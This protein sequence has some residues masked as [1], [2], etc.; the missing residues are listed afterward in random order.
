MRPCATGG[1]ACAAA[2]GGPTSRGPSTKYAPNTAITKTA[3]KSSGAVQLDLSTRRETSFEVVGIGPDSCA[4]GYGLAKA[5]GGATLANATPDE[6]AGYADGT[7]TW[8]TNVAP[9]VRSLVPGL[10]GANPD[11]MFAVG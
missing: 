5:A 6:M 8:G 4:R 3:T 10:T 11:D 1:D 7:D 9:G 2:A